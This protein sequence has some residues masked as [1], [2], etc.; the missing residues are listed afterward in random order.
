MIASDRTIRS[1]TAARSG[2]QSVSKTS[3]PLSRHSDQN[4]AAFERRIK[5]PKRAYGRKVRGARESQ[6]AEDSERVPTTMKPSSLPIAVL[7]AA[8]ITSVHAAERP[9]VGDIITLSSQ[10]LACVDLENTKKLERTRAM[11]GLSAA[12]NFVDRHSPPDNPT[13]GTVM[14]SNAC[15]RLGPG[16]TMYQVKKFYDW[17]SGGLT[18]FCIDLVTKWNLSPPGAVKEPAAEPTCWWGRLEY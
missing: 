6:R 5:S 16:G 3:V 18:L 13:S 17:T 15:S 4:A 12:M 1:S 14:P 10:M 8:A 11:D 7:A 9:Q 2:T